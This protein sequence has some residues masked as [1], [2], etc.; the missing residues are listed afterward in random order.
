MNSKFSGSVPRYYFFLVDAFCLLLFSGQSEVID[1]I[2][3]LSTTRA[4][5][6]LGQFF[7]VFFFI[8]T[9]LGNY[10]AVFCVRAFLQQAKRLFFSWF[11]FAVTQ[12]IIFFLFSF[13]TH[14]EVR[15][16]TWLVCIISIN[17]MMR[18]I[19]QKLVRLFLDQKN[20]IVLCL[21]FEPTDDFQSRIAKKYSL[22]TKLL[23][24]KE[25]T[26]PISVDL[27]DQERCCAV[28]IY[29]DTVEN[30][31][32]YSAIKK[33]CLKYDKPLYVVIS[34]FENFL[35]T[36]L[37]E[38]AILVKLQLKEDQK[39]TSTIPISKRLLDISISLFLLICFFP[40]LLIIT[41]IIK[42]DSRGPVFFRQKRSLAGYSNNHL[43]ITKFRTMIIDAEHSI[44]DIM[45]KKKNTSVVYKDDSDP[46]IT[47][48]G[49]I[50]RKLSID[51]LPQL[52]DVLI[53]KMTLV[54]PRPF[55][56]VV[57]DSLP[58]N[59]LNQILLSIRNTSTAGVTGLWQITKRT[60]STNNEL[61]LL[62]CYYC[63]NQ[64]VIFDLEIILHTI[65]Y[66]MLPKGK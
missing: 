57:F 28:L 53:G 36:H 24:T 59:K 31:R 51:E 29:E 62:D 8:F 40:L 18:F 64:S 3:R 32:H 60:N 54:G 7:F 58:N 2:H 11:C 1:N 50:C 16:L 34:G 38:G 61:F 23:K 35:H 37:I 14:L 56:S 66:L 19:L 43:T 17:C 21:D 48:I 41:I 6:I 55:S 5:I 12:L 13:T 52:F 49:K 46:R 33:W 42:I 25:G 15:H 4:V 44:D 65:I 20:L 63:Q 10:R 47:R 27:R 39:F 22:K 9:S 26:I 45:K 30:E